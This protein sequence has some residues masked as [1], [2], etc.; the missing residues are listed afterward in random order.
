MN[1]LIFLLLYA[2]LS[3]HALNYEL[4]ISFAKKKN[5][6]DKENYFE[7][8]S[9]TGSV[10][11]YFSEQIA[12]ETSYTDA[13]ALRRE[14]VQ[15]QNAK[16]IYQRTKVIGADLIYV[17]VDR[18]SW[19]QPYVKAGAAQLERSQTSSD[20][21]INDV[22]SLDIET[23]TVPS[24]GVGIKFGLTKDLSVR[25]SYDVWKTPVGGGDTS[26]DSQ[27]RAGLSWML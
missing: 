15:G 6:F 21:V 1:K 4:G 27:I 9:T 12:L 8:E 14:K 25:V 13:K 24:Y 7:T 22:Y 26:D 11:I 19:I 20:L 10:S 16:E 5:S 17:L 23:T 3:A 2:S 18:K